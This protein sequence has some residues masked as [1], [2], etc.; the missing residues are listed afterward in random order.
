MKY[1]GINL[2]K[3]VKDL[4][5]GNYKTLMRKIK[6]DINRWRDFP[7]YQIRKISFVKMTILPKEISRFNAI[8]FKLPMAFFIKL[9]KKLWCTETKKTEQSKDS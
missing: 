2:P 4:Y 8:P 3:E 7:C 1:L 5:S 6:D 9:E